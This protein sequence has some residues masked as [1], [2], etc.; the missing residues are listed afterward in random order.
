MESNFCTACYF[1]ETCEIECRHE[2]DFDCIEYVSAKNPDEAA[3]EYLAEGG[4][5]KSIY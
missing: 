1:I 4:C 5:Y 3:A 2:T